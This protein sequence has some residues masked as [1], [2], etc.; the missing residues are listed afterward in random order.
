MA[1]PN[2]LVTVTAVATGG[3]TADLAIIDTNAGTASHRWRYRLAG[4]VW[5]AVPGATTTAPG[6]TTHVLTGLTPGVPY[7][8]S[9]RPENIDGVG[10]YINSASWYTHNTGGGDVGLLLPD[11]VLPTITGSITVN[12]VAATWIQITH[13]AGADDLPGPVTYEY[14]SDGGSTW[15]HSG[16]TSLIYVYRGLPP[17]STRS[18]RVRARDQAGNVSTGYL[19]AT[20]TTSAYSDPWDSALTPAFLATAGLIKDL[21][22]A[23]ETAWLVQDFMPDAPSAIGMRVTKDQPLVLAGI[24]SELFIDFPWVTGDTVRYKW[25]FMFPTGVA[26]DAPRNLWW[27]VTQWHDQPDPALGQTWDNYPPGNNPPVMIAFGELPG[28]LGIVVNYGAPN[29]QY[30]P[31]GPLSIVRGTWYSMEMTVHWSTG[32]DGNAVLKM[33]GAQVWAYTGRNMHN[34][35]RHSWQLGQY[36]AQEIEGVSVMFFDAIEAEVL[37]V[38]RPT[39][40]GSITVLSVQPYSIRISH[41]A[42]SDAVAVTSYE[43]SKDGGTT[44][45]DSGVTDLAFTFTRLIPDTEYVLQ[46]RAKNAE[47]YVSTTPLSTTVSTAAPVVFDTPANR[48]VCTLTVAPGLAGTFV[49]DAAQPGFARFGA[50]HNGKTFSLAAVDAA[51]VG[52]PK[53]EVRTGCTYTHATGTLTRGTL[54]ESSTG[55]AVTL[56][57]DTVVTV[58]LTAVQAAVIMGALS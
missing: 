38:S 57:A 54:E 46:V 53:W 15:V 41:P 51:A 30:R 47:G 29:P 11:T 52:G 8:I 6:V 43:Y 3:T 49:I 24:R 5:F 1:L 22:T 12:Y 17:S 42:G 34:N 28:N 50:A 32:G 18:L 19:S 2:P 45:V 35:Y 23:D 31:P 13:S 25:K 48:I 14:S 58:V 9:V 37:V 27:I 44:W 21:H 56:G 39:I 4:D 40:T 55:A 7:Q 10:D 33:N 26:T 20:A 36:R 16:S